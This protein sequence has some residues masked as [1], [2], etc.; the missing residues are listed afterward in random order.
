MLRFTQAV[1]PIAFPAHDYS[2]FPKLKPRWNLH[3]WAGFGRRAQ[4]AWGNPAVMGV[5]HPP[6]WPGAGSGAAGQG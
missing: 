1:Q 2:S 5:F 3:Y 6:S 4:V